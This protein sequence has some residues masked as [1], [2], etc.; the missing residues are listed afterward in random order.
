MSNN[1][2]RQARVDGVWGAVPDRRELQR[3]A[4]PTPTKIIPPASATTATPYQTQLAAIQIT[5]SQE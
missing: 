5:N 4:G 3:N 1:Y 2:I